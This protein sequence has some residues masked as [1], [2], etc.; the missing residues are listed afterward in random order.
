MSPN[1][2]H[3]PCK[4][5]ALPPPCILCASASVLVLFSALGSIPSLHAHPL[6]SVLR[7][8]TQGSPPPGSLPSHTTSAT[9]ISLSLFRHSQHLPSILPLSVS[10]VSFSSYILCYGRKE[11]GL[12]CF[13]P[14]SMPSTMPLPPRVSYL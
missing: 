3:H 11:R 2:G 14:S 1:L 13:C 12:H 4:L 8:S 7:G 5:R 10:C 9:M 6:L